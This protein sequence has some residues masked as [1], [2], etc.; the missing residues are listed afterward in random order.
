MGI[1]KKQYSSRVAPGKSAGRTEQ[2]HIARYAF[3]SQFVAGKRVLDIACGTGYGSKMMKE[4]GAATVCGVDISPDAITFANRNSRLEGI[5]FVCANAE[6]IDDLGPFDVVA[7]FETIEH[8]HDYKRALANVYRML[9][10]GGSLIMSTPNRPVTSPNAKTVNDRP[11]ND[12]HVREWDLPEFKEIVRE[13]GFTLSEEGIFGQCLP[14]QFP[15]RV[16]RKLN[17]L[18]GWFDNPAFVPDVRPIGQLPRLRF[19]TVLASKPA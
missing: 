2:D 16:M 18:F 6:H 10:P 15:N 1:I 5:E 4:A 11:E 9:V 14:Q 17:K 12:Y 7:S 8:V 19:I 13:A 3:A